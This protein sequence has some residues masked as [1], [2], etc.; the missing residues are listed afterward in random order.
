MFF[1]ITVDTEG[2]N[3][4]G[5]R[6]GQEI[7]TKN[8]SYIPRFQELCEQYGF[9]PVYFTDYEVAC[10]KEWIDYSKPKA[11]AKKCEI[12][13]HLHAWNTE[14]YYELDCRFGGCPYITEY[15]EYFIDQK[16]KTVLSKLNSEYGFLIKSHRA[17]RWATNEVYFEK[18]KEN[19]IEIDCSYTPGID[20]SK[21][22]GFSQ[23][24]GNNYSKELNQISI[25]KSGIIEIPMTT[26]TTHKPI[27]Y[28]PRGI[29]RALLKGNDIWLRPALSSLHSM[30]KLVKK[31]GFKNGFVEF[32][33]HSSEL[34]PAGSP[35]FQT[36]DDIEKLYKIL[37]ELFSYA[38]KLGFEGISLSD[39]K[40]RFDNGF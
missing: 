32:M 26:M 17:G 8:V 12:G 38:R 4:W 15:P 40:K 36:S 37:D 11:L 27:S 3:L 16:I 6:P 31:F 25:L 22:P 28:T 23:M 10:N 35:Y 24:C 30:K 21:I 34:M 29:G 33:V 7:F 2:D 19:G 39:F 5:W 20:L 18:L 13:M 1:I 9:I 14:P